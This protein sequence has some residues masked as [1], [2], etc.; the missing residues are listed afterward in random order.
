M[1]GCA[2]VVGVG[3]SGSICEY[4]YGNKLGF[5]ASSNGNPDSCCGEGSG[6]FNTSCPNCSAGGEA[7]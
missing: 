4:K 2:C 7:A 6:V 3:D 5:A 1:G